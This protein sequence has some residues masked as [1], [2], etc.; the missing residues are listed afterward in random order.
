MYERLPLHSIDLDVKPMSWANDWNNDDND[1]D[2]VQMDTL[3]PPD[4]ARSSTTP[5][6]PC[7]GAATGQHR[8]Q[9]TRDAAAFATGSR[10]RGAAEQPSSISPWLGRVLAVQPQDASLADVSLPSSARSQAHASQVLKVES[11]LLHLIGE[12]AHGFHVI[13]KQLTPYQYPPSTI[14]LVYIQNIDQPP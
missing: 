5:L 11:F 12:D 3:F 9:H 4:S 10:L 7:S 14:R 13:F 2:G 6:S 8:T 1:D